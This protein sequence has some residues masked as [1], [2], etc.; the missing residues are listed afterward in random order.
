MTKIVLILLALNLIIIE[1]KLRSFFGSLYII[2]VKEF[3]N[4]TSIVEFTQL[5]TNSTEAVALNYNNTIK[6]KLENFTMKST[7]QHGNGLCGAGYPI[8]DYD[9][10]ETTEFLDRNIYKSMSL[11]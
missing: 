7:F 1:G 11:E 3:L 10:F 2:K 8:P 6:Q 9:L 4:H 5:I